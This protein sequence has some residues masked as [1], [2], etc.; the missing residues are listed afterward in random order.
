MQS[1]NRRRLVKYAG[2]AAAGTAG[3]SHIGPALAQD[4]ITL[5]W[6]DHY[7]P[8]EG[9]LQEIFDAYS[10]EHP[11]VTV[12]HQL[13]N[14]PELGQSLQLAFNSGQAP[15]VHAIASLMVPTARLVDEGWFT[16]IEDYVSKEFKQ[17]FPDAALLDGLHRFNGDLYSFPMF[18][19]RSHSTT[20]WFN[21]A[22]VEEAGVDPEVGPQTWDEFRQT[23]A[24]ITENGGGQVFGWIQAIGLTERFGTQ[25][26][27]LAQTAGAPGEIDWHTGE[28]VYH[29]EPFLQAFEFLTSMQDDGSL[30][31]ASTTLDSRTARA[32]F[33]TGA[34]GLNF[35]GPWCI[36]VI[37]DDYAEFADQ[38]NASHIPVPDLDSPSYV[39][40]GPVG[41]DFWVS[42]QS[43]H[44]EI[45]AS[46]LEGFNTP[47]FYVRL[48]EQMDQPPLDISAVQEADVHP[49]YQRALEAYEERVRLAPVPEVGN[50]DVSEV[51][52]RMTDIRPNLG[53]IAQSVFSGDVSDVAAT[54]KE[55]SD[56]MT[57]ER[58]RAIASAQKDGLDVSVD[59]WVFPNWELG[60]DFTSEQYQ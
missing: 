23:A 51:L 47:E 16:P 33:S 45:A 46:I 14:L 13:Y 58:D 53:E 59:D 32:R 19:F 48:A 3:L 42:S 25:I 20:T 2:A 4:D 21:K 8:L 18:S 35:D 1:M 36:G 31:P 28:Y 10:A 38:V 5:T 50:P 26:T 52:S 22:L 49:S 34:A 24:T 7:A 15:D 60:A 55:Y 54:L 39:T 9:L 43:E 57:A 37:V 40:R 17:R 44:P 29:S 56:K 27:Q 6:W 11:N 30:F 41:G 12:E